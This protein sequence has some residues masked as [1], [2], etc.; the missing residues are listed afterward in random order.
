LLWRLSS[1]EIART[2]GPTEDGAGQRVILLA[3]A[4]PEPR[5]GMRTDLLKISGGLERVDS[6][7]LSRARAICKWARRSS[8]LEHYGG[9]RD[10]RW[11][12]VLAFFA[13]S[14]ASVGSSNESTMGAAG[15]RWC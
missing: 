3:L 5:P 6:G 1:G 4:Y 11:S 8:A 12:S 2:G 13:A 7:E 10:Y 9:G 14:K 15:M